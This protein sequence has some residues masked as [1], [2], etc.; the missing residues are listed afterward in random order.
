MLE[1]DGVLILDQRNYDGHL[2]RPLRLEAQI[3]LLR[4]RR[5]GRARFRYA[6]PDG[7]V[8]HLNMY[9]LRKYY[10][11]RLLHEVETF[12]DFQKTY[13]DDDEPGRR[14]G[15]SEWPTRAVAP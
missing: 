4:Q 3:L 5:R 11:T 10:T 6:F 7:S 1:H 9:P 15:A 12:G 13:R 2:E 8:F 14:F